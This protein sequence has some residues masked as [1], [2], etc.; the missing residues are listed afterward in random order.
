MGQLSFSPS[1]SSKSI[2]I[3]GNDIT[4]APSLNYEHIKIYPNKPINYAL[5]VDTS[6]RTFTITLT[7]APSITTVFN[8]VVDITTK[9]VEIVFD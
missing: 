4:L 9:G 8:Y 3:N 7:D 1:E 6:K 2:T 5:T